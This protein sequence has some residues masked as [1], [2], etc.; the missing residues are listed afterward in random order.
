MGIVQVSI[1]GRFLKASRVPTYCLPSSEPW[2]DAFRDMTP[3][4][5]PNPWALLLWGRIGFF[6][7]NVVSSE[8]RDSKAPSE[9]LPRVKIPLVANTHPRQVDPGIGFFC[10]L[11]WNSFHAGRHSA[12]L[13]ARSQGKVAHKAAKG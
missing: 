10:T 11:E 2:E 6:G 12:W 13:P 7:S 9:I 4:W 3:G 8:T 1:F 5:E